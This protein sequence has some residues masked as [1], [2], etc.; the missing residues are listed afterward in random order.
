MILPHCHVSLLMLNGQRLLDFTDGFPSRA[1]EAPA[2]TSSRR[3]SDAVALPPDHEASAPGSLDP[4]PAARHAADEAGFG[5]GPAAAARNKRAV[6]DL[7]P[8]RWLYMFLV[9]ASTVAAVTQMAGVFQVDGFSAR[10]ITILVLFAILFAWIASSF[11][12]TVFGAFAR[13]TKA[14]LLP[15]KPAT[16][17][18]AARTAI[19]MPIYNEDVARVFSRRAR[20]PGLGGR[21]FRL[22]HPQRQHQSRQ[23]GG[24]GTGLAEAAS[25][26]WEGGARSIT[27]I[28]PATSGAKP[29]TSRTSARIGASSMTIWSSWTPTA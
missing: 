28:A 19:L 9:L 18:S 26:S 22:L 23:L 1:F 10:E 16:G 17:P 7:A 25:A 8:R 12:L 3:D 11:W 29:A 21:R 5:P 14:E 13:F 6:P 27:V 15:L 20:H 24:R 2:E 4:Y